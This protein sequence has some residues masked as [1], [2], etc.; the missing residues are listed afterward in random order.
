MPTLLIACLLHQST[1]MY[2]FPGACVPVQDLAFQADGPGD[3][4]GVRVGRAGPGE[5]YVHPVLHVG[6]QA[7]QV[8][9]IVVGRSPELSFDHQ[10]GDGAA[11]FGAVRRVRVAEEAGCGVDPAAQ[12]CGEVAEDGLGVGAK[13]E[14]RNRSPS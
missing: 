11:E 14:N 7:G 6:L 5:G 4:R 3:G 9:G 8:D 13:R 12:G 1:V 10:P 2:V